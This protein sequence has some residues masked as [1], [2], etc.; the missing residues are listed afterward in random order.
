MPKNSGL[1]KHQLEIITEAASEAVTKHLEKKK[2][3]EKAE[4]RER[5]LKNTDL[6][7]KNYTKLKAMAEEYEYEIEE[8]EDSVLDLTEL[9]LETLERYH[10]KTVKIMKHVDTMLRAYEW[11]CNKGTV[12]EKRRFEVLKYRFLVDDKLTARELCERLNVDQKTIYRD[13]KASIRDM[14][15]LLFGVSAIEFV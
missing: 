4:Q 1:T 2:K 13:S 7:M 10:L 8:Y 14:S 3:R 5:N 15:V 6:L 11:S 12:E 9:N